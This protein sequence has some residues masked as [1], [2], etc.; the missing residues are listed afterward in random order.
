MSIPGFTLLAH[1]CF[2]PNCASSARGAMPRPGRVCGHFRAYRVYGLKWRW[3]W[4]CAYCS[5]T[6]KRYTPLWLALAQSISSWAGWVRWE[7]KVWLM[8][9]RAARG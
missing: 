2:C 6:V 1:T 9:R 8:L 3:R 5:L 7:L 4:S